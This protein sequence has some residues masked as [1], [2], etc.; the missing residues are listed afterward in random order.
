M[1]IL[2][3]LQKKDAGG[4][5]NLIINFAWPYDNDSRGMSCLPFFS[6]FLNQVCAWFPEIALRK[7]CMCVC[8]YV[9]MYVYLFVFLHP[10]EQTFY[11]KTACIQPIKAK[12][13]LYYTHAQVS[14]AS[15]VSLASQTLF[16]AGLIAFSRRPHGRVWGI[17]ITFCE[18]D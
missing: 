8:M 18:L 9:C 4:N 17:W 16:R 15:K 2:W 7:V 5:R 6:R 11:L 13:S 12:Q 3:Y 1:K 10:R 14:S